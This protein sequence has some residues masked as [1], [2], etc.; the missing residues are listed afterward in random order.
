MYE[1]EQNECGQVFNAK[2]NA[3]RIPWKMYEISAMAIFLH[4][5]I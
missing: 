2:L 1:S 4:V 3:H 5:Y